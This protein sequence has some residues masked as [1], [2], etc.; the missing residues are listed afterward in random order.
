M[1]PTVLQ[2][3]LLPVVDRRSLY[4]DHINVTLHCTNYCMAL[5]V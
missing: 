5:F 2:A 3:K 4:S 1:H